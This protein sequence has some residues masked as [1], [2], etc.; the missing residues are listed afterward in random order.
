MLS[1]NVRVAAIL[2]A[3]TITC[4]CMEVTTVVAVKK[5]GSGTITETMYMSPAFQAMMEQMMAGMGGWL[6]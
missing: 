6:T 5:D 3:L 1:R 4:G 2:A